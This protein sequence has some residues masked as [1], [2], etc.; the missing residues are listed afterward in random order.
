MEIIA[1][2]NETQS[3]RMAAR[4]HCLPPIYLLKKSQ[5]Y[6]T[7]NHDWNKSNRYR[8]QNRSLVETL[9]VS[10]RVYLE[11]KKQKHLGVLFF[12][13]II[14]GSLIF[15]QFFMMLSGFP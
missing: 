8:M 10:T 12:F 13:G 3:A 9:R 14:E 4:F 2:F 11:K 1:L 7:L 5:V 15:C 6:R